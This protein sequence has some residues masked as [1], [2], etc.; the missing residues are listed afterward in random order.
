M[1]Q[2]RGRPR[3]DGSS[4]RLPADPGGLVIAARW[5]VFQ[6]YYPVNAAARVSHGEL[7]LLEAYNG[8]YMFCWEFFF[9]GFLLLGLRP[10]LGMGAAPA[11]DPSS[12]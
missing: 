7:F 9:R 5:P 10:A 4:C 3:G 12:G 1:A 8:L 2:Q 11:G 6:N